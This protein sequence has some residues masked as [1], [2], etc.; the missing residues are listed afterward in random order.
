MFPCISNF[1]EEISSLS[2]FVV[3]L[4]FFAIFLIYI[5]VIYF[6]IQSLNWVAC[7]VT[8][9]SGLKERKKKK[10]TLYV[11]KTNECRG[12]K[13][14]VLSSSLR[15]P[16]SCLLPRVPDFL[17]TCLGIDCLITVLQFVEY[18]SFVSLGRFIPRYFILSDVLINEMVSLISISDLLSLVYRYATDFSVLIL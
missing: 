2:H 1:L 6:L 16:D 13:S 11:T 12:E 10:K 18:R 3:F 8:I 4:Y 17:S 5:V 14:V 15:I 7:C 9:S